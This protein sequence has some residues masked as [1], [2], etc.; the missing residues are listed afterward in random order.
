LTT[1]TAN[2]EKNLKNARELFDSYLNSIFVRESKDWDERPL[3]DL[4]ALFS[5]SAHRTPKYQSE[6]I[7]AL[8]PRDVVNGTLSLTEA[9][10]VSEQEYQIQSKRH[11]PTAGDIV[12]SRELSY[13]WAAVLPETPRVCLSQGMCLFRPKP[14]IETSFLLYVLN[15]P[16]GRKQA[17]KAAV[18][19]AHPHINLGD[20]KNYRIPS[21]TLN[22]QRKII[23]ELD[24]LSEH[25]Q[26]LATSY[27]SKLS[28]VSNLRQS[29]LQK[30]FTGELSSAPPRAVQEAAE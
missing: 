18:G 25:T 16:A 23:A 24:V 21:P 4:C 28:M 14:E 5:D 17:I 27:V 9:A 11:Q 30:A 2:A 3:G 26:R 13:G 29:I 6:G 20:I 22:R 19:T 15:G 10:R 8:R 7:P 1:A 12:Y